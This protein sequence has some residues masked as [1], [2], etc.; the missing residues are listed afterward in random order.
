[1]VAQAEALGLFHVPGESEPSDES[2]ATMRK[3]SCLLWQ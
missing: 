2:L 1:M 3:G